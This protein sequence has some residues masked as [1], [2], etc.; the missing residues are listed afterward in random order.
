M[1]L[2]ANDATMALERDKTGRPVMML[3][4]ARSGR[5]SF[6]V[7]ISDVENLMLADA[8][9]GLG[10]FG[11]DVDD[12]WLNVVAETPRQVSVTLHIAMEIALVPAGITFKAHI[13]VDNAM[14]AKVTNMTLEGDDV[15]GPL[16]A[17]FMR[18]KIVQH[19]NE[20]RPL[21]AFPMGKIKLHDISM[22]VD[23]SLRLEAA[24]GD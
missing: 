21:V 5:L 19:N 3:E 23:D 2:T 18:P 20:T 17:D 8:Q 9:E 12:I 1:G 16:V 22:K 24:F 4:D 10:H 7:K 14:N 11:V 13:A 15:L 6:V